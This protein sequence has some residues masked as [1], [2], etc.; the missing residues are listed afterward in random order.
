V[1]IHI[2]KREEARRLIE[3]IGIVP[4][5]RAS[6]PREA[7]L[8]AEAVSKG[9]IP[10]VEITLTVPGALQVISEL[11]KT[12]PELLVG[13]GTVLNKDLA[14]QCA[15]AG[16]QFL[17]TPGFEK[18]SVAVAHKFDL[19]IMVGALT[20]TEVMAAWE[21]GVDFVKIF[22]CGNLGGPSYIKALKGPLPQVPLVPTGGVNLENAADYI[23]A[24]AVALGV[25]GELILKEALQEQ[26]VKLISEL[27][28]RYA[29]LV[30][31]ARKQSHNPV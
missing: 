10:I 24:G 7:R 31:N 18:E 6:S 15:E 26:K 1:G 3:E 30:K 16:A 20:P 21:A 11:V 29:E 4:V 19:P 25:G 13:A 22:P 5:I 17:V 23:R 27:A 28:M 2:M 14:R 12:M 9:G 8:A